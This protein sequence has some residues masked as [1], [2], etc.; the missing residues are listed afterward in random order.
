MKVVNVKRIVFL[1]RITDNGS[2]LSVAS[3]AVEMNVKI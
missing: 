1:Y 2:S 3:N